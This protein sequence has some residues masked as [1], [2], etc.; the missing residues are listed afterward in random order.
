MREADVRAI[1]K[2]DSTC[3]YCIPLITMYCILPAPALFPNYTKWPWSLK[4]QKM[5]W[6]QPPALSMF[7]TVFLLLCFLG[8][9]RSVS[10]QRWEDMIKCP[11]LCVLRDPWFWFRCVCVHVCMSR[12][13]VPESPG[14]GYSCQSST[15][16]CI[17]EKVTR[18][19]L[20]R[21]QE[22]ELNIL[23]QIDKGRAWDVCTKFEQKAINIWIY[24]L[25]NLMIVSE[26]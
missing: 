6:P 19:M 21:Q 13:C 4:L 26:K 7:I 5:N 3:W 2:A 11:S 8:R 20:N 25:H 17:T 22:R 18:R 1:N 9:I 16:D 10:S 15:E 14:L 23:K 12:Y 24:I